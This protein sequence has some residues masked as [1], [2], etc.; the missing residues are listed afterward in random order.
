M[1]VNSSEMD[2][3]IKVL[4]LGFHALEHI[5]GLNDPQSAMELLDKAMGVIRTEMDS[6]NAVTMKARILRHYTIAFRRQNYLEL[7]L[8]NVKRA[9]QLYETA[10]A[11]PYDYANLI[12]EHA[13][14]LEM[15]HKTNM[16]PDIEQEIGTLWEI[17]ASQ[18]VRAKA[19][20]FPT[21]VFVIRARQAMF[22]MKAWAGMPQSELVQPNPHQLRKAEE[23]LQ[24]CGEFKTSYQPSGYKVQ[25]NI[26]YSYLRFWQ[27]KST[28]AIAHTKAAI[29]HYKDC[30]R[31]DEQVVARM[32]DRLQWLQSLTPDHPLQSKN[33]VLLQVLS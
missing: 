16:H 19:Y 15:L 26:A 7:A 14:I 29:R 10:Q 20:Q 6:N 18:I 33:D 27:G 17:G 2:P 13:A 12:C 9:K 24:L 1:L 28:E 21:V 3:S 23:C 5:H 8:D 32:K 30:Q 11:P 31:V 25:F 22:H 4:A